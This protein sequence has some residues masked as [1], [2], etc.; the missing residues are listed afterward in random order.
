[1]N[2]NGITKIPTFKSGNFAFSSTYDR[3]ELDPRIY[4]LTILYKTVISLP[5]LPEW[6][7][8]F[9]SEIIKKSIFGTAALEGNPL[10][11]ED[12]GKI[13]EDKGKKEA[14]QRAEQEIINLKT[15]YETIRQKKPAA[16]PVKLEEST[17][18]ETHKAI[19]R[20]IDY[21]ANIPGNYRTHEVKVGDRDHGGV[22]TPPKCLPDIQNLMKEFCTWMNSE[23]TMSL[24]AFVRAALSHYY[25]G[26]IHPFGDGNGRTARVMEAS[27][28]HL[29]GIRLVPTMLSNY[30]Y[31]NL[32]DY[33]WAFS[34]AR[35]N[36]D[37]DLTPFIRFVLDGIMASLKEIEQGVVSNLQ[38]LLMREY[39][40]FLRKSKMITQR[41]NDL[42]DTVLHY[43][44]YETITL[45]DLMHTSPY[46]ALYRATSE[47]TARR[48]LQRLYDLSLLRL[49][50]GKYSLNF[51]TFQ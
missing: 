20:N 23:E 49:D 41:Q 12:V 47:R 30:Y 2:K 3:T 21:V 27:L 19:T 7:A 5:I 25:L 18:K 9:N 48:D 15:V 45:Q 40:A 50:Q 34:L 8:R 36:K 4:G 44:P 31:K 6:S 11:E 10:S 24:D 17:I 32:D 33:F 26:L 38:R 37:H 14:G 29:S 28:L 35:K 51:A 43:D 22:Y 42:I 46:K 16:Q 13:I 39:L 1:M